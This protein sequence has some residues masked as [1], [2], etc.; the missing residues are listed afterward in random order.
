LTATNWVHYVTS[1]FCFLAP[2]SII[3]IVT[4]YRLDGLG[5]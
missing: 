3:D 2:G 5:I 1:H 4:G